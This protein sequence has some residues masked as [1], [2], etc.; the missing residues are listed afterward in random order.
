MV[1]KQ[2]T[3]TLRI[4]EER[5]NCVME[6]IEC[7]LSSTL[8][9]TKLAEIAH[10][11]PYH[12]HRV[13]HSITGKTIQ[14]FIIQKRLSATIYRLLYS[15]RMTI[16]E[17]AHDCGFL[18]PVNFTR[19]FKSFYKISPTGYR[20]QVQR[21]RPIPDINNQLTKLFNIECNKEY[22]ELI[23]T[24]NIDDMYIASIRNVGLSKFF[25]NQN[26]KNSFKK[27]Y[28]WAKSR[29]LIND[30]TRVLGVILDNP[31]II[32]LRRCCYLSCITVPPGIK[33]DGKIG[34]RKLLSGGKYAVCSF[35]RTSKGFREKFF[36]LT[37]YVYG[38]WMVNNGYLPDE[39]PFLEIY[40][41]SKK[42]EVLM[43]FYIPIKPL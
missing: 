37:D 17:I 14:N 1:E 13:F 31:E 39:K 19:S 10:F 30:Q 23:D 18:S 24:T 28:I 36:K 33:P 20:N 5:V 38:Y 27:L 7:N 2:Y 16:T 22:E 42:N 34:I 8:N 41:S 12:F 3:N 6:Y 15:P 35:I 40:R 43:D 29:G 21:K 26:I 25:Y 11:S 9:L 4:Y 32:P